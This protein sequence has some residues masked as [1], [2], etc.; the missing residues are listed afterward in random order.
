[1]KKFIWMIL[2]VVMMLG[3]FS[4]PVQAQERIENQFVIMYDVSGSMEEVDPN[5][6]LKDMIA[7]FVDKLARSFC[8]YKIAV[9]PFAKD[10]KN[11]TSGDEY[12]WY[13]K[14]YNDRSTIDEI[15]KAIGRLEY[16]GSDTDIGN[17]M[18]YCSK[19]LQNMKEGVTECR[20]TVLFITDGLIDIGK[21]SDPQ[22]FHN[23]VVSYEKLMEVAA[24]FPNDCFFM[25]I[26]PDESNKSKMVTFENDK[27][28]K[29]NNITVP[30]DY[31]SQ[32][33]KAINGMEEFTK[34]LGERQPKGILYPAN[35]TKID[36]TVSGVI[37]KFRDKYEEFIGIIT[38]STTV[39]KEEVNVSDGFDFNV[40]EAVVEV[41]IN[42]EPVTNNVEQK[43]SI[44]KQLL[45]SGIQLIGKNQKEGQAPDYEVFNSN[46]SITIKL[47]EP[48]EGIYKIENIGNIDIAVDIRFMAYG[49]L[50]IELDSMDLEGVLGQTVQLNGEVIDER[51]GG[52]SDETIANLNI[53]YKDQEDSIEKEITLFQNGKFS[54][55]YQLTGTGD[56]YITVGITYRDVEKQVDPDGITNFKVIKG[57]IHVKVPI[58]EYEI[59][60]PIE[61]KAHEN[62]QLT[63]RP[64]SVLN[65]RK[66]A[67]QASACSKYLKDR[68]TVSDE[69]GSIGNLEVSQD[70]DVFYLEMVF[71][72]EGIYTL[73]FQNETQDIS[74]SYQ[75][76]V[77]DFHFPLITLAA[78]MIVFIIIVLIILLYRKLDTMNIVDIYYGNRYKRISLDDNGKARQTFRFGRKKGEIYYDDGKILA[79]FEGEE[80]LAE[81]NRIYL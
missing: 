33:F 79:L 73:L 41:N 17:A 61:A 76:K 15:K 69:S 23:I 75:Y 40:P 3:S 71:D 42:L 11:I 39:K 54:N 31:Q 9:I 53:W 64:Y 44:V 12:W 45:S 14:D 63:I 6:I 52:L 19:I 28:I 77:T 21:K 65:G 55:D 2:I 27:V 36:W 37:D 46:S 30:N 81:D 24:F 5:G 34:K 51:N 72:E 29:F 38:G 43:R 1:M 56:K 60:E 4:F 25:G 62:V 48:E 57:P 74:I 50:N 18:E 32:M 68:W 8:P 78:I 35:L 66:V 26:V 49:S 13:L 20:Q 22:K 58:V 59:V 7:L 80:Y 47:F 70:G 67:V 10:V 16:D